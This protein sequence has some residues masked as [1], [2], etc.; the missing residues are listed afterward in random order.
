MIR[1]ALSLPVLCF[2]S[3]AFGQAQ[4]PT[5]PAVNPGRP[6]VTDVASLTQPGYLE[7]EAGLSYLTGSGI[8]YQYGGSFLFKLTDKSALDEFRLST[9]GYIFQRADGGDKAKGLSDTVLG[10]QRLLSSQGG[11]GFDTAIRLETKLP[12]APDTIGTGK[13]DF[14]V[15]LLAS[16]DFTDRFHADFNLGDAFLGRP[17]NGKYTSQGFASAACSYK[18][19]PTLALQTELYGFAGNSLNA[20]NVG[21]G[22][23]VAYS[24]RPDQVFDAYIGFGLSSGA[25]RYFVTFGYTCFLAK[26]F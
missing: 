14:N 2:A 15:L 24:P 20:T 18:V 9:N 3:L 12:T 10:F 5:A 21:N 25:P 4:T 17:E 1:F 8:D 6:T 19:S 26:L 7:L 16:K 13:T 11:H 23:A 22:Y